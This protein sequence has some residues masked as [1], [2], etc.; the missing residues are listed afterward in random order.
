[1]SVA[2]VEGLDGRRERR[3]KGVWQRPLDWLALPVVN[4]GDQKFVGLYAVFDHPSNFCALTATGNYTVDW[5]DGS[6]PENFATGTLAG[7]VY[8]FADPDLGPLTSEGFKTVVVTVTP[9]AGQNLANLNLVQRHTGAGTQVYSTGWLDIRLGSQSLTA[10]AIGSLGGVVLARLLRQ[11]EFV[12]L[13]A[14]GLTNASTLF[15]NCTSLESVVGTAWTANVTD[16]SAMFY[17]CS[18]LESIPLL[19][20]AKATTM[21]QMFQGCTR[22]K[23]I[24]LLDTALCTAFSNTFAACFNL[25]TI[26][27]L[28]TGSGTTFGAMFS[29][30]TRL[31]TVPLLD[32][33]KS[34]GFAS[35]F[36]SCKRLRTVPLFNTSKATNFSQMFIS[37]E[38]LRTVPLFDMHLATNATNMFFQ[39]LF[40]EKVP[41]LDF[42]IINT[43]YGSLFSSCQNLAM[44]DARGMKLSVSITNA[45][46]SATELNRI[47][48]NLASGVTAQTITVTGNYG[49]TADDPSIATA[50]GWTVSPP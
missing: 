28:N 42:S 22:L 38:Q 43:S 16:F 48:T 34:L 46:L 39:C 21:S 37:C 7:H 33:S 10:L 1:M 23:S 35:M 27:L 40:L 47:Y 32:T 26:P 4:P 14:A 19:N 31:T 45:R 24:P 13:P 9:Q 49:T 2:T 12:G 5:G 29:N 25:K 15:Q 8:D 20:T 30:C 36:S 41:A 50:K 17:G 11:F 3:L 6:A 18:A 44:M